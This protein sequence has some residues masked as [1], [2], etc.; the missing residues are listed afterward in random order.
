MDV[1]KPTKSSYFGT[2]LTNLFIQGC[3]V[4]QGVLLARMLGPAGRGEF[5]TILLWPNVFAGLGI[6]GVNMAIS[7]FAG[8]G[9]ASGSLVKTAIRAG[10]TTGI[11]SAIACGLA[12][13]ALL[14]EGKHNLLPVAYLFLLFAPLNHLALN[15]QGIDQGR[16]NFGWLNATRAILNPVYLIGLLLCWFFTVDKVHWAAVVL[17]LANSSVVLLQLLQ[18]R[19]Y[20]WNSD[21]GIGT[22]ILFNESYPFL[23]A[24]IIT[25]F[26]MQMD[27]ALLVWWLPPEEIG[28]YVAAFS[29]AASVNVLNSA[30]GIV[31]FTAATQAENG[32]GFAALASVLRRGGIF[33]MMGGG[34]LAALLPWLL[35]LVYGEG[36]QPATFIAFLL[37]PGLVLAGLGEII[38]QAL[39]GQGQPVA[40]VMSKVLGLAV[41]GIVGAVL[42]KK[43]GGRGIACGYL[44]GELVAFGGILLV[45]MHYYRD[46]TWS[47]LRPSMADA[48]FLCSRVFNKGEVEI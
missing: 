35:P 15:L 13:P 40:G 7:R 3:A 31:Q 2:F 33:S 42:A 38:N 26:Y 22:M 37:L 12:L 32:H 48:L 8:K 6:L 4:L 10:L 30:L 23:A 28:W 5:A 43:F 27:K 29:A 11:L 41:M 1:R 16:G 18:K 34:L 20:L 25:I 47:A 9:Q 45:A 24:S 46:S 17:L 19:Q 44:A 21:R 39:R 14:P 36:F